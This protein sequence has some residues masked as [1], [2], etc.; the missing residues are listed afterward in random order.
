MAQSAGRVLGCLLMLG[1]V[2]VGTVRGQ[3]FEGKSVT[4]V[5]V[6]INGPRTVD[7]ERL[8]A[9]IQ[10][11]PGT[12]YK[13]DTIDNDIKSLYDSGLI[14]DVRV[15]AEPVGGGV[16]VVYEVSPREGVI[17]IGFIGNSVF[18]DTK[19]AKASKMKAGGALSDQAILEAR[20]NIEQ[21]YMDS[22]YPDV[23]SPTASRPRLREMVRS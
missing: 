16:R 19:L 18:S 11:A 21:H 6:R 9:F 7:E 2:C 20:Q 13:S 10:L 5:E 4:G 23:T 15:L 12:T 1:A 14:N 22:G 17:A 8:K 3:D